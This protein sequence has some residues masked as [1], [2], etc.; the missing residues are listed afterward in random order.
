MR[1]E[2]HYDLD[3]NNNIIARHFVE[4]APGMYPQYTHPTL[5]VAPVD[6]IHLITA[7]FKGT[8]PILNT[9]WDL[10]TNHPTYP[11]K[12]RMQAFIGEVVRL[13]D[14]ASRTLLGV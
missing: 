3:Q 1:I 5:G 6:V 7:F 10:P 13:N 4:T 8:I 9:G 2:F 11:G 12:T 14:A